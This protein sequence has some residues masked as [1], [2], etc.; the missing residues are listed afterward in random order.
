MLV[1]EGWG[2]GAW[3]AQL[4]KHPTEVMISLFLGSSSESGSELTAR[5][6]LGILS[7][8]LSLPLPCSCSRSLSLSLSLSLNKLKK[9]DRRGGME[10]LLKDLTDA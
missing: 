4:V 2:W 1:G 9:K 10:A 3:V 6:L 8:T 5:S 7:L